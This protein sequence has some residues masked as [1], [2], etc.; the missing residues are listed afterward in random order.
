MTRISS[1]LASY[2]R[3]MAVPWQSAL[4]PAKRVVMCVYNPE[5]EL[6]LRLQ[7]G[8]FEI[9]TR[10]TEH[11]WISFDLTDTFAEWLS[12]Q[13]YAKSYFQKP[14]LLSTLYPRYLDCLVERVDCYLKENVPDEY[15]VVA[16][17]GVGSL[18]GFLKV[19]EL[20]ERLAPMVQGRLLVFFPEPMYTTT[21]GY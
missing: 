8:E 13:R 9:A 17:M 1:L 3:F 11:G 7:V 14:G 10:R 5:D 2:S 15:A 19:Q 6:R 20:I 18:F 16:L 4:A 21:T 12:S